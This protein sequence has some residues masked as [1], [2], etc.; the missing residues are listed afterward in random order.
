MNADLAQ[1]L[2]RA[3]VRT[4][5]FVTFVVPETRIAKSAKESGGG[6]EGRCRELYLLMGEI[7]AQLR[8]PVGMTSVSWLSSPELALAC[9]T[10]FAPATEPGSSRPSPWGSRTRG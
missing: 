2:T 7:E 6:I 1:G 9:R 3:S 5:Q 10:G 8:G 4:E